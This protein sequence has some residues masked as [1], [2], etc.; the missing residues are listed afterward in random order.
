MLYIIEQR[1]SAQNIDKEKAAKGMQII[2]ISISIKH[3]I[4][5]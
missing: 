4:N 1:L 3:L 2:L 5:F